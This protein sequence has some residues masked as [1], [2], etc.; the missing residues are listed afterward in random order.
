MRESLNN[1]AMLM[2]GSITAA[3]AKSEASFDVPSLRKCNRH[4]ASRHPESSDDRITREPIIPYKSGKIYV[5]EYHDF[6]NRVLTTSRGP[7]A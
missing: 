4:R 1:C 5:K 2:R 3:S 7:N 6:Q